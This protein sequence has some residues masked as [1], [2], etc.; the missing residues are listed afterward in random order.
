MGMLKEGVRLDRV[1]G[2]RQKYRRNLNASSL[3]I[4]PSNPLNPIQCLE[5]I[6]LIEIL[7]GLET[8]QQNVGSYM[9]DILNR[10]SNISPKGGRL[11]VDAQEILSV[12]SDLYDKELVGIIGWA[13]QVPGFTDLPLNDQMHLLQV[14]WAEI[15]TLMLAH[16]SVP[17]TGRLKFAS[18]FWLDE[19]TAREC[20]AV[21]LYNHVCNISELILSHILYYNTFSITVFSCCAT[22]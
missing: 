12:L 13:K 10:N 14:S 4:Q 11:G 7:S 20:D 19:R 2:G 5:D 9:L 16:R 8:D 21:E 1:R 15:L 3:Q 22:I 17:F 18:D 6:K